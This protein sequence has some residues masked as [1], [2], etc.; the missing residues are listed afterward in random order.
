MAQTVLILGASG[1]FGRHAAKA[2]ETAGWTVLRFDRARDDLAAAMRG[3]DVTVNAMNPPSYELWPNELLPLHQR[4]IDAA[5]GSGTTLIVPGNVYVFGPKAPFGWGE[6]TPHRAE[7]TLGKLRIKMEQMYRDSGVQTIL[8]RCGDFIDTEVSVNWFEAY[9]ANRAHDGRFRYPGDPDA[10]H[11]WAYLPDAARAAVALAEARDT[12]SRYEDVPFEGWALSG[13]QMADAIASA[14]GHDVALKP[15]AWW[16]LLLLRPVMPKLGGVIEMRY[17]WSLPQQLDG[18]KLS[19]LAPGFR[20]TAPEQG[21][22][23]ALA[24]QQRDRE[25]TEATV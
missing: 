22:R 18:A 13:R 17:L 21:L 20:A 7:N 11:A 4:V 16:P 8:L 19:T 24:W 12:L 14:L 23:T 1:R 10:P 5:K 6:E 15:M 3:A 9:L 25:W 2:F